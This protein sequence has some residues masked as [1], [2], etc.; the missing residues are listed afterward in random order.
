MNM[1]GNEISFLKRNLC[2]FIYFSKFIIL[3]IRRIKKVWC[4]DIME[5][6]LVMKRIKFFIFND[7]MGIEKI[8]LNEVIEI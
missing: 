1:K 2:F 5:C 3:I 7:V 8:I 4:I 6:Y